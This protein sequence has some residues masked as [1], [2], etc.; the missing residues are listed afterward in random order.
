[1]DRQYCVYI[2]TNKY[3]T[4][5]YTGITNDLQRRVYEHKAK[6]AKGFSKKYDLYKL[7]Y[8]EMTG[9]VKAA[10][11]REKQIKGGSRQNKIDL[12]NQMNPEWNDLYTEF[13]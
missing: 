2:I 1:M 12:I 7:V 6:L 13:I 8:Y 11:E 9:D 10:I 5:L 4:T 3:H